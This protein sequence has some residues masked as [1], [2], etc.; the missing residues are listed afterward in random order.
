MRVG[1]EGVARCYLSLEEQA[2]WRKT[3][4]AFWLATLLPFVLFTSYLS[5]ASQI[6][7]TALF[8]LS[9]DLILGY[10]GIVSLGHAAFFGLGAYAA[11][12]I[13]KHGWGE[14]LSGLVLAAAVA[15]LCG[16]AMSF[17][18][19][20]FRHLALIM[21]TLGLGL[22]LYEAANSASWLT[23]GAD[24]LQGVRMWP[25]LGRFRFDLYGITAY[26]YSLVVLFLLF[27]AARRLIHSPFGLAL[28]GIRENP[29]R[30]PAIGAASHAHIRKIYTIAAVIAGAAGALLAQTTSTVSLEVL[31]FPRSADVLVILIL[32][33]AG[34]LY[35]GI[36][37][38][39]IYMVARDLFS[40]VNPQYWYFWIGLL[41]IAVVIFLPN[42]IL[43]GLARW[44]ASWRRGTP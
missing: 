35:G 14:P 33:G 30:M 42:G 37:G 17:I 11:G 22:L 6:A 26:S 36:V 39:I 13:A 24:G 38:A 8:A 32:G 12:L 3:E 43:G 9:L 19:A 16:Y 1:T 2:R 18:I 34:R 4:I 41:L 40:G 5:L 29:V 44:T 10:A 31:G 7:I 20:R 23:G 27:L 28:R 15:G 21:I 25:L